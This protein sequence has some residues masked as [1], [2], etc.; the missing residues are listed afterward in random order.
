MASMTQFLIGIA[1]II[2][3]FLI[4]RAIVL[5]YWGISKIIRL[6]E[7]IADNLK[8]KSKEEEK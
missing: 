5:W 6:L 4:F 2:A 8:N 1:V 3:L 7:E